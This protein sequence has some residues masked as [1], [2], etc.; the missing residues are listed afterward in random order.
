M[1][2]TS[3]LAVIALL[4]FF[5]RAS[6]VV[7]FWLAFVLTRPFGATFGDWLTKPLDHGGLA[8]GTVGASAVFML[9]LVLAVSREAWLEHRGRPISELD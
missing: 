7:L 9:I 4:H 5:T 6:G 8:L 1:L 2:F 3:S